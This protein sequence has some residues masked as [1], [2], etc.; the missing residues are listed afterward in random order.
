MWEG[1]GAYR[2][3]VREGDLLEDPG[4]DVRIILK[5]IYEKWDGS[6]AGMDWIDLPT[7]KDRWRGCCE[8]GNEPSGCI[9]CREFLE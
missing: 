3:L 9:K 4:V 5:W 7:D 8:C 1:R 2:V 6:G